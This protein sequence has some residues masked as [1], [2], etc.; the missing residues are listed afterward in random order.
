MSIWIYDDDDNDDFVRVLRI[1]QDYAS[2]RSTGLQRTRSHSLKFPPKLI[3]TR[4]FKAHMAHTVP[5]RLHHFVPKFSGW[6]PWDVPSCLKYFIVSALK[7]RLYSPLRAEGVWTPGFQWPATPLPAP[8]APRRIRN[9][10]SD[11]RRYGRG[12]LERR[13][14]AA[15]LPEP[16]SHR[17]MINGKRSADAATG[18][19]SAHSKHPEATASIHRGHSARHRSYHRPLKSVGQ[20]T[21]VVVPIK[22]HRPTGAAYVTLVTWFTLSYYRR[23][24]DEDKADKTVCNTVTSPHHARR[25]VY[26]Q[27]NLRRPCLP[28]GRTKDLEP[29]AC[30]SL[31]RDLLIDV[32]SRIEDIPFPL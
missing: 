5:L 1:W 9:A 2:R 32:S 30:I 28:S 26:V 25:P 8:S 18:T 12:P 4:N 7:K 16:I 11:R 3:L 6:D 13:L 20:Q 15:G 21:G 19:G 31:D 14:A 22:Y 23:N 29:F 24:F 17:T 10:L 27:V